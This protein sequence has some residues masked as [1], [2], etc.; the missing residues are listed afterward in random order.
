MKGR[1]MK[2]RRWFAFGA[3]LAAVGLLTVFKVM[4]DDPVLKITQTASNVFQIQITNGTNTAYYELYHTPALDDPAYPWT[5]LV[6]GYQ[7]QTNFSVTNLA[8]LRGFFLGGQGLDW[9]G[10]GVNNASDAAPTNASIGQLTI[11]I[12]SPT[13]G[14]VFQ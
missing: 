14:A 4:A 13:N 8:N 9:D 12:D 5:L 1:A 11:T 3:A 2:E 7:G 10:D 6:V